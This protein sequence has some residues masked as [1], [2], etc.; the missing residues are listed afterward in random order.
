M[1]AGVESSGEPSTRA[2]EAFN[3][4]C[5]HLGLLG[6]AFASD[7]IRFKIQHRMGPAHNTSHS[8]PGRLNAGGAG[9]MPGR[10]RASVQGLTPTCPRRAASG[11]SRP[12]W[13]QA[14]GWVC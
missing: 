9:G 10:M 8:P 14:G 7:P 11:A 4:R 2:Q 13:R 5:R 6:E 12:P 3:E 1:C